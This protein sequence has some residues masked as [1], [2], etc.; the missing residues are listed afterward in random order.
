LNCAAS[1]KVE[2]LGDQVIDPLSYYRVPHGNVQGSP[3]IA[4]KVQGSHRYTDR[5]VVLG[6]RREDMDVRYLRSHKRFSDGLATAPEITREL[7]SGSASLVEKW[8][9]T[10]TLIGVGVIGDA[11]A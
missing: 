6:T 5:M 8:T 4:S 2:F 10:E 11:T 1:G 9:A 7:G 3:L